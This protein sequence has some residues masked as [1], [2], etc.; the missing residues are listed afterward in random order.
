MS[1]I[2]TV[3]SSLALARRLPSGL[4]ATENT[5]PVWPVRTPRA[6][7]LSNVRMLASASLVG[8][9]AQAAAARRAD[10]SGSLGQDWL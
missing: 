9:I 10:V 6:G 7:R 8:K 1:Q 4:N 2:R 3:W 5:Q